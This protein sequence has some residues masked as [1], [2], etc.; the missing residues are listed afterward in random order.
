MLGSSRSTSGV[1]FGANTVSAQNGFFLL[2]HPPTPA[3]DTIKVKSMQN[4]INHRVSKTLSRTKYSNRTEFNG[5]ATAKITSRPQLRDSFQSKLPARLRRYLG[6]MIILPS[7]LFSSFVSRSMTP[8]NAGV[9]G[10]S[11]VRELES[12]T[13]AVSRNYFLD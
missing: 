13:S 7:L 11:A 9:T 4:E 10:F 1:C 2:L 6:S 12:W 3:C 8:R 5:R